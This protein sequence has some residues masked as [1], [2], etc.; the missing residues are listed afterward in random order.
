[1]NAEEFSNEWDLYWNNISSNQAPG[2]NEYEKSVFLTRAQLELIQ[3][4]FSPKKNKVMEG[5]ESSPKRNMDFSKLILSY[6]CKCEST[7]YDFNYDARGLLITLPS[8]TFLTVNEQLYI[9]RMGT[10]GEDGEETNPSYTVDLQRILDE[11]AELEEEGNSEKAQDKY[12][13][14]IGILTNQNFK[15]NT[16]CIVLRQILR[17]NFMEYQRL[18]TKAYKEPLKTQCW[19]LTTE[20]VDDPNNTSGKSLRL[21]I[22]P[23]SIESMQIKGSNPT[24]NA[25]YVLRYIKK[26]RPIILTDLS[27]YYDNISI[28]GYVGN[29]EC[30]NVR[31][32][33]VITT[34]CELDESMHKEIL[35]RAIELAKATYAGDFQSTVV[36]AQVSG[37]EL[38]SVQQQQQRE[39]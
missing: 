17:L 38:G 32:D 27:T 3:A 26:P 31:E 21:E 33:G 14:A 20:G 22:I 37:T 39:R 23:R 19:A 24:R 15:T 4:Y 1:M 36:G 34:P 16:N 8:N 10:V 13:Q 7:Q 25:Y 9:G 11:A 35:Q 29:E 6:I 5:F 2:L 18:M 30:Y 28:D 12:K